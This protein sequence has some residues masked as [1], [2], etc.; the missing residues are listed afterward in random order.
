MIIDVIREAEN[1]HEIY[2][3]VAAYIEAVRFC[4]K[5]H[6]MPGSITRLPL[7]GMNDVKTR[8]STLMTELDTA[9]RRLDERSCTV[10]KEGLEIFGIALDRLAFLEQNMRDRPADRNDRRER[11][12]RG[13]VRPGVN[14]RAYGSPSP[15]FPNARA[16]F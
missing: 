14:P 12:R 8:F 13:D 2:F 4:D 6:C 11:S 7:S 10:L 9:S 16:P 15:Y 5:L 1:E 3:L